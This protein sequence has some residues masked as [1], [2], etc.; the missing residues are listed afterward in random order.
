M[1]GEGVMPSLLLCVCLFLGAGH[2][3][4]Q[5]NAAITME[6]YGA[7]YFSGENSSWQTL[8]INKAQREQIEK[9]LNH[10]FSQ[11]RIRYWGQGSRTGWIFEEIGKELP[12]TVGVIVEDE[13]IVD[14]TVLEYRESRG[15]EVVYPFFT[16]QFNA[17]SLTQGKKIGL[18]KSIDG[19]TGATMSVRALKKIATLALYCHQQTEFSQVTM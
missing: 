10:S 7:R 11:I 17:A 2:A 13:K 12:I 3:C 8:W 19:I 4:A 5:T 6:S 15:G 16:G 18:D 14:L 9:I 1:S